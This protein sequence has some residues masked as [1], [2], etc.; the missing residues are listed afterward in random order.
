M[1]RHSGNKGHIQRI[2]VL[3]GNLT[4][5]HSTSGDS[6]HMFHFPAS[7]VIVG[8]FVPLPGLSGDNGHPGQCRGLALSLF[9][10]RL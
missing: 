3:M 1:G 2:P 9:R 7:P 4:I 8:T 5:R 10:L 6:A